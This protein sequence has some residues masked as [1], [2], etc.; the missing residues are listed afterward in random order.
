MRFS[1]SLVNLLGRASS[2]KSSDSS[3]DASSYCYLFL[4]LSRF[5][6][7]LTGTFYATTFSSLAKS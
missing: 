3:L 2:F 6:S 4:T 7:G 5:L 1:R